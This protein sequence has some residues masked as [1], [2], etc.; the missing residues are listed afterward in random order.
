MYLFKEKT[1]HF[2]VSA[3]A[4]NLNDKPINPFQEHFQAFLDSISQCGKDDC[5]FPAQI[6]YENDEKKKLTEQTKSTFLFF[7]FYK[8]KVSKKKKNRYR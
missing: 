4:D 5:V 8:M 6:N 1:T 3:L 2:S 7:W